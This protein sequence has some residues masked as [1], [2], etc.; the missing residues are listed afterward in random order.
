MPV[1]GDTFTTFIDGSGV[2]AVWEGVHIDGMYVTNQGRDVVFLRNDSGVT[3]Y[4]S[5]DAG[6]G[7]CSMGYNHEWPVTAILTGGQK[8]HAQLPT[9]QF[10]DGQG[11][12]SIRFWADSAGTTPLAD[13]GG[14]YASGIAGMVIRSSTV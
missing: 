5:I 11:R 14:G 3:I 10:N 12:A 7:M 1:P 2:D 9:H 13:G 8:F 4:Y 6:N